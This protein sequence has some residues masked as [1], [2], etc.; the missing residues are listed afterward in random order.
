MKL[1]RVMKEM[2]KAGFCGV[3]AVLSYIAFE[4]I[5]EQHNKKSDDVTNEQFKYI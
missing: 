5:L 1:K 2:L 3:L 4:H